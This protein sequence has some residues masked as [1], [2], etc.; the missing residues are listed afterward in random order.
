MQVGALVGGKTVG[1]GPR[2]TVRA[3]ARLMATEDVGSLTVTHEGALEGI[4]T[5]RDV[6]RAVAHGSDLD[7]E[8]VDDWMTPEPDTVSADLNV[9]EAA[10]WMLATG[11]R[12]LP[13]TSETGELIG[14]AS[15]KDVLWA[16]VEPRAHRH[17]VPRG[18]D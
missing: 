5:E 1:C 15:I 13:V 7:V 14:V 9:E 18:Q 3:A 10:N 6:L 12:H 17:T 11:Y 8:T 4:L 16:L 2:T